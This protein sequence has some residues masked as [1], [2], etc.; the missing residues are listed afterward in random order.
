MDFDPQRHGMI[1]MVCGS[2]LATLKLSTIK[3]H[4]RQKH[5]DSL[6]WSAADKDVIRSG[7]ESHLSL[8]GGQRSYSSAAGPS[9]EEEEEQLDSEQ[10]AAGEFKFIYL[11]KGLQAFRIHPPPKQSLK[12]E[13]F[14]HFYKF[15]GWTQ[16][17]PSFTE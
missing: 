3:R 1:C 12:M 10:H 5:P 13:I 7:W 8:G 2:S 17:I 9:L 14:F 16:D 6:L 4:I 11:K 15:P